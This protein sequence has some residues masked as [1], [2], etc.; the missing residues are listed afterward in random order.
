MDLYLAANSLLH[1]NK[2][3]EITKYVPTGDSH[4]NVEFRSD[5]RVV[6]RDSSN[7]KLT[8]SKM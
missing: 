2:L 6:P 3:E 5:R 4:Q 7:V 8:V 1:Y